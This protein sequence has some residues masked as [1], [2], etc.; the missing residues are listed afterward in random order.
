MKI[1]LAQA[2]A[3]K[4]DVNAN[5]DNHKK[6]IER[7][8]P[9]RADFIVFPELSLTGYEPALANGLATSKDDKRFDELQGLSDSNKLIIG[10]G[11]P[12]KTDDGIMIGMIIFQPFQPRK[13]YFKQYIHPDEEPYFIKGAYQS[14]LNETNIALAICFEI[15]VPA[16]A[17]QAHNNGAEI[18]I[19]SVAKTV[20]GMNKAIDSLSATAN[21]Y[22]MTVLV[23]N[24]VGECEGKKAGGRSSVWNNKGML[25][26]QLNEKDEGLIIF[27]TDSQGVIKEHKNIHSNEFNSELS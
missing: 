16:H 13:T 15:S 19:A 23:S 25:L 6:L 18:Y 9:H 1:C 8:V 5:L 27:D 4:G 24:C 26:E 14:V 2:M 3:V 11:M 22:S 20:D 21:R 7:A 12:I 10:A 17:E